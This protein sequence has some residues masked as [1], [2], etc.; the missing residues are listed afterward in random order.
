MAAGRQRGLAL[1]GAIP[2]PDPKTEN[3]RGELFS[4]MSLY[5]IRIALGEGYGKFSSEPG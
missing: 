5:C 3:D 4:R 1:A 2:R